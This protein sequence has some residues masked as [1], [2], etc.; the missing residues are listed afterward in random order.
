MVFVA[1][2]FVCSLLMAIDSL[3]FV[4][5]ALFVVL[6][7]MFSAIMVLGQFASYRSVLT[8]KPLP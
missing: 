4:G 3:S 7:L 5:I 6:M 2:A 8:D 1:L